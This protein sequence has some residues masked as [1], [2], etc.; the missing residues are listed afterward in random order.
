MTIRTDVAE[1]LHQ[2]LSDN[3]VSRRLHCDAKTVART[4]VALG[5]PKAKSGYRSAASVVDLFHARTEPLE[6]GHLQWTGYAS[7]RGLASVRYAGHIHTALRIAFRI[8]HERE[9][10]GHCSTD[11][12]MEGCV[13]PAHVEDDT[14]RTRNRAAYAGLIGVESPTV[15]CRRG[16][17]AAE[18]RRYRRDGRPYCL[19]CT[20]GTSAGGS[21]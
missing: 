12:G 13:A 7:K 4:R 19:P 17:R 1:L 6:G 18:H 3:A 21:Q 15:T 2:G 20:T 9:P 14:I 10:V 8:Q 16:H 11:C 5:L